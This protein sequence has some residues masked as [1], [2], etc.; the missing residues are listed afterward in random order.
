MEFASHL[1]VGSDPAGILF[2]P[3]QLGH[4]QLRSRFVMPGM[5]RGWC[6]DGAPEPE[7]ALYYRRRV[8]G[9]VGLI[10]GESA[11]VDCESATLQPSACRMTN[12]TAEAW[13]RCVDAVHEA[14][15]SMLLQ[16]WHEGGLRN[17]ADGQTVSPSGIAYPGRE[18]GRAATRSDL[19]VIRDAF[20]RSAR[21]A[22]FL[23]ADGI[24]IHACHGYLLD[25][26]LWHATNWRDDGY[27][28]ARIEDRVRFPAEIVS[29]VR[30]ECGSSFV[31]SFRFSQWKEH[32]YAARI[33]V[34]P[35]E[36]GTMTQLLKDAGAN[37]LHASTRR[38]WIPEWVGSDL[39][40]AGWTRQV[41]G[42]PTIAVGS[43]GLDR[44]VMA[45]FQEETEAQL[46]VKLSID[47]L[48][49]R[50]ARSEFDLVAVGRSLISDPDWVLKV[51]AGE[52]DTIR[53]FRKDDIRSLQWEW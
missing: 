41:G 29:A 9:G 16:L 48:G 22:M 37:L 17:P 42:L 4:M 23:G 33:A 10:I 40:L 47:E 49:R 3:F 20:V 26:F 15:G 21:I 6:K 35:E 53:S 51:A 31:I 11:A 8:Q 30:A 46:R 5:Q 32:E 44:D 2:S 14:G 45:S 50:M 43:V 39:G 27:G 34:T 38:F 7:L 1:M 19:E 28:G 36:L 52:Y 18:G 25:Q 24:E 12:A 13:S